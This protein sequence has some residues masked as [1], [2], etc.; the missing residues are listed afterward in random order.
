MLLYE[1]FKINDLHLHQDKS[2]QNILASNNTIIASGTGSGKTEIFFIPIVDFCIK[3]RNPGIKAIII[4]P[5]NSLANDQIDRLRD[6]LFPINNKLDSPITFG[7]Y[8]GETPDD[9]SDTSFN[10]LSNVHYTCP[11]CKK[12]ELVAKKIGRKSYL[13]CNV[14]SG[15]SVRYQLLTR[16]EMKENPPDILITNYVQLQYLMLRKADEKLLLNNKV[17]FIILDEIHAYSGAK[18]ID[19]SLLLRRFRKRILDNGGNPKSIGTSATLS[20]H[21]SP[22]ERKIEIADFACKLFGVTIRSVDVFE[23]EKEEMTFKDS[24]VPIQLLTQ[25]GDLEDENEK[26]KICRLLDPRYSFNKDEDNLTISKLLQKNKFFQ[27]LLKLLQEPRNIEDISKIL[28]TNTEFSPLIQNSSVNI[29]DAVWNF[30]KLGS[31]VPNPNI[32][33]KSVPLIRV[34]I[35]NFFKSIDPIFCCVNCNKLFSSQRDACD[36]CHCVIEQLGVCRFC[37]KEFLITYANEDDILA[38]I[39]QNDKKEMRDLIGE[40]V[41]EFGLQCFPYLHAQANSEKEVWQTVDFIEGSMKMKKCKKCGSLSTNLDLVC[42]FSGLHDTKCNSTE[43]KE[44]YLI[45]VLADN[46]KIKSCPH[47]CPFCNNSY[48]RF[49][50]LSNLNLSPNTAS[51][52][53][54]DLVYG[55][56]P[57]EIHKM[58]IFTD[59]RQSA[60]HFAGLLEMDHLT[61]TIRN[62]LFL[63]VKKEHDYGRIRYRELKD[64]ALFRIQEWYGGDM[65]SFNVIER[66]ILTSIDEELTSTVG[67]QR[68]LE[69]LG[70]LETAYNGLE[71][72][73][74]FEKNLQKYLIHLDIIPLENDEKLDN[75]RKYLIS[76]LNIARNYGAFSSLSFREYSEDGKPVGFYLSKGTSAIS[77]NPNIELKNILADGKPFADENTEYYYRKYSDSVPIRMVTEEDTGALESNKRRDIE[78]KF[79][80]NDIKERKIDVVVATPT[81]E[82][83]VDIGDLHC[84]GLLRTPPNPSNYFQRVGR[85]GRTSGISFNN[86][87]VF[88]NS[89]DTYYY[90]QPDELI[91]GEVS[92][93]FINL[94]NH[95][96]IQRH[97]NAIIIEDLFVHSNSYQ[98]FPQLLREFAEDPNTID[99]L[100]AQILARKQVV[101]SEIREAFSDSHFLKL[102]DVDI[103]NMIDNF[104]SS[105]IK[106]IEKYKDDL[107]RY[108][109]KKVDIINMKRQATTNDIKER[110]LIFRIRYTN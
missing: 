40:S 57:E 35:H 105:I 25:L 98:R 107:K 52:T 15:V 88:Q 102:N 41:N 87:F 23:G 54:F 3:N 75:F 76:L 96:M 56:L 26:Q 17:N 29:R 73:D 85:A 90:R 30:L 82:L 67:K 80:Q 101:F 32:K 77:S 58:L 66:N 19:V 24:T 47:Y 79:K 31:L 20:R 21:M 55:E 6:I 69:N 93:P 13:E 94:N 22:E 43:F 14:E 1:G 51:S 78:I 103:D 71:S 99:I 28:T 91:K 63:L 4:Y 12:E 110:N 50:A 16:A 38:V 36:K 5:M 48:G 62:L 34:N 64:K 97:T 8:T 27:E 10:E 9:T 68:S 2:I 72:K 86:T 45:T 61:H 89:I 104:Q 109:Q 33:D 49:S 83:G 42:N 81:L 65:E 95:H 39:Q 11:Q 74:E 7:M 106:S 44:I 60:S 84:I 59:N 108:K 92:P 37:G 18:G 53:F 70:L 100:K 46:G